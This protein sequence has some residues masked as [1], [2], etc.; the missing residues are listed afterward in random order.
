[1]GINNTCF[2]TMQTADISPPSAS[3]P[4]SPIK[5]VAGWQLQSKYASS[6]PKTAPLKIKTLLYSFISV[7]SK[8]TTD[9]NSTN[10]MPTNPTKNA[11]L[12]PPA[13]PSKPSV[14]FTAFVVARNIKMQNGM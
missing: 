7:P 14:K 10:S 11:K 2:V 12:T 5:I 6:E 8:I 3:E 4:V 1:M 13:R 9:F